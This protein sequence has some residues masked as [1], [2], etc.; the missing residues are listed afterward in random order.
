MDMVQ[1]P[2][3]GEW[4]ELTLQRFGCLFQVLNCVANTSPGSARRMRRVV[5]QH[6]QTLWLHQPCK[7]MYVLTP[8]ALKTV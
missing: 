8:L 2:Q 1:N 3:R 7:P 5:Q 4:H 6:I